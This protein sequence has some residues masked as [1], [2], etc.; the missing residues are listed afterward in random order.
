ML[1]AGR[2]EMSTP[3]SCPQIN[4]PRLHQIIERGYI[5]ASKHSCGMAGREVCH[6]TCL[7]EPQISQ[8]MNQYVKFDLPTLESPALPLYRLC[9]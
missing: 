3:N 5:R 8:G 1:K 6:A 2:A 9:S 4:Y 7:L